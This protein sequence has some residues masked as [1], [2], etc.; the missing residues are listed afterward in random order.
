MTTSLTL[1][2]YIFDLFSIKSE[3]ASLLLRATISLPS[4]RKY[5]MSVPFKERPQRFTTRNDFQ[6]YHDGW[7]SM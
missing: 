2:E 4:T 7:R 6:A 3:M 5:R 1:S